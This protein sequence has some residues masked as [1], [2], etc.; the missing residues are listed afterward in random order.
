MIIA[1]HDATTGWKSLIEEAAIEQGITG[2]YIAID[3]LP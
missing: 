1:R 2:K 3:E